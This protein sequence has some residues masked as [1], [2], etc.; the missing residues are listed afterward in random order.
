MSNQLRKK[1]MLLDFLNSLM[2]IMAFSISM[3]VLCLIGGSILFVSCAE[4]SGYISK[5]EQIYLVMILCLSSIPFFWIG[6]RVFE[7]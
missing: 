4:N 2:R 6:I 3:I 7:K 5:A 1:N